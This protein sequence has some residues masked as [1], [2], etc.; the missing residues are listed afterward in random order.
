MPITPDHTARLQ[1]VYHATIALAEEVGEFLRAEARTFR[2]EAVEEKGWHDFVSYVDKTAEGMIIPRLRELLPEAG[3]V[4]EE[5]GGTEKAEEFNWIV[6]PLDGTTNFIHGLSPF[7]VS[8]GLTFHDVPVLGVIHEATHRETFHAMQGQGA[9]QGGN[10]IHASG[11]SSVDAALVATGFPYTDYSSM[12]PFFQSMDYF[13]RNSHGLRRLGSAA[14]DLAY[15]A[16]GRVDA[17]YEY[18]LHAWDVAA[19]I[20]ICL[21][22]G[23]RFADFQGG[24]DYLYGGELLCAGSGMFEEF[25]RI[26]TG[27]YRV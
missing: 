9:Y 7:A 24:D 8:I 14:T 2:K 27:F 5:G 3:V 10:P 13:M 16:A 23:V 11:C 22:A 6:D 1:P 25:K 21:E 17:F 15:V 18:G 19:G 26:V 12:G 4:S 20:A